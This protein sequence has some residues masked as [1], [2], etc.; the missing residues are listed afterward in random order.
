MPDLSAGMVS[1]SSL[2]PLMQYV[3]EFLRPTASKQTLVNDSAVG[4]ASSG[5]VAHVAP[6]GAKQ[7]TNNIYLDDPDKFTPADLAHELVH[8]VQRGTG[9]VKGGQVDTSGI[10]AQKDATKQAAQ[11]EKTYGYGG[12]A[13]ASNLKSIS[14]LN[15][16][17]QA[18]M[19]SDYMKQ[20][21]G[22]AK[23][24]TVGDLASIDAIN[25]AYRRP[26]QQ[27]ANMA[28]PGNT[29]DTTPAAPGPPPAVL[30]GQAK[31]LAQIGAALPSVSMDKTPVLR[32]PFMFQ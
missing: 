25:D 14:R 1:K 9:A 16:E 15:D 28:R 2:A 23:G 30:T 12:A 29:I 27:L 31:P 13:G 18:N 8:Q 3:P 6:F 21:S 7:D 32:V 11:Y 24:G 22:S 19:V 26:I 20:Y 5:S 4:G 10:L 17:Q